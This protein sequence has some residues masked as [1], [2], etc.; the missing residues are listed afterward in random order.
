MGEQMPNRRARRPGRLV[1]VDDTLLRGHEHG[2][3]GDRLRHG[4]EADRVRRVAVALGA[5]IPRH[6]PRGGERHR[7][8]VDLA[9]GLHAARY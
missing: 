8:A 2:E 3:S 5:A 9:K 4:R 7:P 1:E 6:D